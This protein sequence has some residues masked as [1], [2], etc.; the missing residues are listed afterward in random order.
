MNTKDMLFGIWNL[1]THFFDSQ[2]A[3]KTKTWNISHYHE[4]WTGPATLY[5]CDML[6]II[7]SLMCNPMFEGHM[8]FTAEQ[9]FTKEGVRRY[10]EIHWSTFWWETQVSLTLYLISQVLNS[11]GN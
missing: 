5:Y 2:Q 3:F 4:S 8:S 11:S 10:G 6:A 1:S 9:H 7:Q